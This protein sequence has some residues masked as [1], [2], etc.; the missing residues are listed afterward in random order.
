MNIK[1]LL[2]G[3]AAAL[4]AVS[5]ARAADAVFAPE[6]E[7]VE[8]VRVCDAYGAGFFYIPGTQTCL[9]IGGFVRAEY[10]IMNARTTA[11]P[12][13]PLMD[14]TMTSSARDTKSLRRQSP[15]ASDHPTWSSPVVKSSV[16]R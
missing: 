11:F 5:G 7:P 2:L 13:G 10:A 6:P 14:S 16:I 1:G 3:S 15:R 9:R 4:V 8:Y 12:G